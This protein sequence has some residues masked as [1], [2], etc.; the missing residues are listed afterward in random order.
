AVSGA[1]AAR[2]SCGSTTLAGVAG[3]EVLGGASAN[4][5]VVFRHST[6]RVLDMHESQARAEKPRHSYTR[7]V[8]GRDRF[9][10]CEYVRVI[11]TYNRPTRLTNPSAVH[12]AVS[13]ADPATLPEFDRPVT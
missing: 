5:L 12:S 10:S 8:D 1:A 9:T 4:W 3:I 11:A 7:A 6:F 2:S 13:R